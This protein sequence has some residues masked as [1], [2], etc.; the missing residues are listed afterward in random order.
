MAKRILEERAELRR[1]G[2]SQ[3]GEE[4]QME[5]PVDI[6]G[7]EYHFGI[8]FD[9]MLSNVEDANNATNHSSPLANPIERQNDENFQNVNNQQVFEN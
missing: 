4:E 5:G 9:R 8:N 6:N 1:S 3:M 7:P 2:T